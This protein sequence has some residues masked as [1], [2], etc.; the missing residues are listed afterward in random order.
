VASLEEQEDKVSALLYGREGSHKTTNTLEA[1]KRGRVFVINAEAGVKRNALIQHGIKPGNVELWPDNPSQL[2]IERLEDKA[3]ELR[4]DLEK[5]GESWYAAVFDSFTEIANRLL[6]KEVQRAV[7]KAARLGKARDRW[8]IELGD[9]GVTATQLRTTL[10]LFRDLPVHLF[11]TALERRD[12]DQKTSEVTYGPALSPAVAVDTM[13][14][15]DLVLYCRPEEIGGEIFSVAYS[16]AFELRRAKDRFNVLPTKMVLPTATRLIDYV[17]GV[18]DKDSDPERKRA[19]A[20][21]QAEAGTTPE[22]T[23]ETSGSESETES[24]APEE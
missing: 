15:A 10:R 23:E 7:E 8:Q 2:T 11:I 14:L 13:G 21:M 19:I 5:D 6:E 20:A 24:D 18:L 4:D 1:S 22:E 9:R 12:V 3:L 16:T 17:E